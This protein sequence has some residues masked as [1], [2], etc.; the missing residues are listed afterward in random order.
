[1]RLLRTSASIVPAA[2]PP[3]SQLGLETTLAAMADATKAAIPADLDCWSGWCGEEGRSP[4]LPDPEDL[5]RYVNALDGRAKKPAT[6]ARPIACAR[7]VHRLM[8]FAGAAP[9][10]HH[11]HVPAGLNAH[12]ERH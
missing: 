7:N 6:T 10:P 2:L 9:P 4:L 11:T 8:G 5:V 3:I 1:M 12:Q